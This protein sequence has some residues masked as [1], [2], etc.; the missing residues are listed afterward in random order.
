MKPGLNE[1]GCRLL[2]QGRQP[3]AIAVLR[4]AVELYPR[5]SSAYDSLAEA[6]EVSGDRTASLQVTRQALDVLAGQGLPDAERARIAEVL[7]ARVKRL[8]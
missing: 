8:Q 3:A 5:S 2:R 4:A 7:D 1:I 6:L